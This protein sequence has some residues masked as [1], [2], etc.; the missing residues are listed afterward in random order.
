MKKI[1][2]ILTATAVISL[3]PAYSQ[4]REKNAM[5]KKVFTVLKTK[6]EKGFVKLFPDAATTKKYILQM[7]G[8][9]SSLGMLKEMM[10]E[11]TDSSLQEEY[12]TD[13][14]QIISRGEKKGVEWSSATLVKYTLDS[15]ISEEGMPMLNGK[16]YFNSKGK[17]Y[18]LSYNDII[19]FG[20]EGWYGVNIERVDLKSKENEPEVIDWEVFGTDSVAI[21]DSVFKQDIKKPVEKPKPPPAKNKP[22]VKNGKQTPGRLPE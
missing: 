12:G 19:K 17:A 9:D 5:V 7:M 16:I 2:C 15:S 4:V 6:D 8:G 20:D 22:P 10:A 3:A 18:F 21:A 1:A 14:Q 11:I 13:F